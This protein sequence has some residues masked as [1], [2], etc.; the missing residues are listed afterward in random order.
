MNNQE[1]L[2]V[3]Y[4]N[5][6]KC[7]DCYRCVR[8]CPV[9]AIK[10]ENGQA[11]VIPENCISCGTCI[12]ECPQH[13]KTYI[14]QIDE[15]LEFLAS[16]IPV[17]MSIAPSFASVYNTGERK[18]LPTALR[19]AGFA[20]VTETAV[21]AY[22]V[23]LKTRTIIEK[24]PDKSHI[25]SA[26]PAIVNYIEKY[27]KNRISNI[28]PVVSPMIAHAKILRKEFG[29]PCKI[30]FAGPCVAK[31]DEARREE[32]RNIIDAV[33]TFEELNEI[34]RYKNI[35]LKKCKE[36]AFDSKAGGY[37]KL[38][39]LE[40]GL[41]KT[42]GINQELNPNHVFSLTG[43]ED[44]KD[45]FETVRETGENYIIEPLFCRSGCING[46]VMR[47]KY[48]LRKKQAI[49]NYNSECEIEMPEARFQDMLQANYVVK[50]R[51]DEQQF[52]EEQIQEVLKYTGKLNE[53]DQLNCG[54]CGYNTC[55]D[56]ALAVLHGIAEMEMCIPY[57]RK[58]AEQKNDKLIYAD[59]NGIILL[60]KNL[61]I[62]SMNPAFRKMFNCSD[63]LIGKEIS[64]LI[65]PEPFEKL[66]TKKE[67]K[68]S[69][70]V[71]YMSYNLVCHQIC[72]SIEE[73]NQYVGIFVDITDTQ[74][75]KEKLRDLK[76]ETIIQAQELIDHQIKMAQELARF[77]GDHTARG[78]MLMNRLINEIEK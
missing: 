44:V 70:V 39:P 6:A 25:C 20:V 22:E 3:V 49:I 77:I 35:D 75:N 28:V 13:A 21:G 45:A 63:K 74:H 40:A 41:L 61:E 30:V 48:L 66:L 38:F 8:V 46:P 67:S 58:L 55:K 53:V 32:Y 23:A 71:K 65:D 64:Y 52:D 59:P 68:Y 69:D 15:V 18:S 10:M 34:L 29:K 62:I 2:S 54:A 33:I 4:T 14:K 5:K 43:F 42:A 36:G 11:K 19:E 76:T 9:N 60:N 47:E 31:K 37:A 57:M 16:K 12:P 56:K 17:L 26:C 24:E 1:I 51:I 50:N 78:E 27:C 72:Y 7:R 73:E